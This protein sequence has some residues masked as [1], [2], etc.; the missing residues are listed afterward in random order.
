MGY[1]LGGDVMYVILLERVQEAAELGLSVSSLVPALL[2]WCGSYGVGLAGGGREEVV[3]G[4]LF[5]FD[6]RTAL[7]STLFFIVPCLQAGTGPE[8]RCWSSISPNR[9]ML[10]L[11]PLALV[12]SCA[13][14]RGYAAGAGGRL[15]VSGLPVSQV[16]GRDSARGRALGAGLGKSSQRVGL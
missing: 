14:G 7:K 3:L 10:L 12:A 1:V 9:A 5:P 6:C 11:F 16:H 4:A 13:V 8:H 15:A 2:L